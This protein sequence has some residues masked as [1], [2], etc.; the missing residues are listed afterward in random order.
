MKAMKIRTIACFVFLVLLDLAFS[1]E[2]APIDVVR[3]FY[4]KYIEYINLNSGKS[5]RPHIAFSK[6]FQA[7]LNRNRYVCDNYATGICGWQADGD[8]YLDS[9]EF[10]PNLTFAN[11]GITFRSIGKDIVLVKLNV[12]P[13][14]PDDNDKKFYLREIEYKM[15]YENGTWVVDD[16]I[17]KPSGSSRK[18][19]EK[20]TADYLA[21][22]D[23][24]SKI[25]KRRK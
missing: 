16:I 13:S 12:Y 11:S 24:D 3:D 17:Y 21:N 1:S 18:A 19:I 15:I 20:E 25:M 9:Q 7:A 10:D 23:P 2:S 22:P 6:Q 5:P 14:A 4:R 8:E